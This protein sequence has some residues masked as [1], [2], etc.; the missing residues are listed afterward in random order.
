MEIE[1]KHTGDGIMFTSMLAI[2]RRYWVVLTVFLV[3][4]I[5]LP[6]LG[7]WQVP[8]VV[9]GADRRAVGR[10]WGVSGDKGVFKA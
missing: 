2:C 4:G 7:G 6:G 8:S 3:G 10:S 5:L 1:A 9:G